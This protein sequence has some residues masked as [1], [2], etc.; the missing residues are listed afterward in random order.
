MS[1]WTDFNT[2]APSDLIPR[3]SIVPVHLDFRC[4]SA[5]AARPISRTGS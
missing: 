4:V 3:G 2:A 1:P 5:G